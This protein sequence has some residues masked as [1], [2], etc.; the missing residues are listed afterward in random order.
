MAKAAIIKE[1]LARMKVPRERKQKV[2]VGVVVGPWSS[3]E[4]EHVVVGF[5][6]AEVWR[7][8]AVYVAEQVT[9]LD[10]WEEDA[11]DGPS[12]RVLLDKGRYPEAVARY[13]DAE[14]GSALVFTDT[15]LKPKC[16]GED[17][18]IDS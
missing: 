18:N 16:V 9:D 17:P 15:V 12:L 1:Q 2:W 6:E 13:F 4:P 8:L 3:G 7:R 14:D 5:T 11:D 10:D